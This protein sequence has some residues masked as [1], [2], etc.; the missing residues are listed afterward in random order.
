M[1][2]IIRGPRPGRKF[3]LDKRVS[4]IGK[5][6]AADIQIVAHGVSRSHAKVILVDD[7]PMAVINVVDLESTNGTFVNR[8][9]VDMAMVREKEMIQ[10]GAHLTLTLS[11]RAVA[12]AEEPVVELTPRQLEVARLV[13]AGARNA[14]IARSLDVTPRTVA[15]HLERIYGALGMGSRTELTRWMVE[16]GL[17]HG[18]GG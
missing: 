17:H 8:G 15:S 4:V 7:G 3:A 12:V 9:R 6:R 2:E 10:L 13:V 18:P 11:R 14:E 1:L 5:S 16:Q